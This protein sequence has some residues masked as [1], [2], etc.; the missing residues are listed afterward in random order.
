MS[1][2][3]VTC[4]RGPNHR[5]NAGLDIKSYFH[6]VLLL[7][8]SLPDSVLVAA[9]IE[10]AEAAPKC[11]RTKP[12]RTPRL[13]KTTFLVIHGL[14][15]VLRSMVANTSDH[16]RIL[17]LGI[18]FQRIRGTLV[19]HGGIRRRSGKK[20]AWECPSANSALDPLSS[21][22]PFLHLAV[23]TKG[24]TISWFRRASN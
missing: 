13:D 5:G 4:E 20:T 6:T 17:S 15:W 22:L 21:E 24:Q 23:T 1:R 18:R 8:P 14:Q 9:Q 19:G 11:P 16:R 10:S 7:H 3:Q 2:F 12:T